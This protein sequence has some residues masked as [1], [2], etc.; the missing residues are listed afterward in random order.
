MP[1]GPDAYVDPSLR[2]ALAESRALDSGTD[3]MLGVVYRHLAPDRVEATMEVTETHVQPYGVLHGGLSVTLAESICSVGA[4][5]WT[6]PQGKFAV[7]MEIN[8]NHLH[9]AKIGETVTGVATPLHSGRDTHVWEARLTNGSG[10]LTCVARC[11]VK[12]LKSAKR[13]AL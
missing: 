1:L 12:V 7:G 13:S 6:M 2:D 10:V 5:L 3:V 8:A 11:T 9:S 4:N